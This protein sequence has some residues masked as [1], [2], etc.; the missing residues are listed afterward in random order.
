MRIL[1]SPRLVPGI[2]E[3]LMSLNQAGLVVFGYSTLDAATFESLIRPLLST[4]P[5]QILP[6]FE[7]P[8][9]L[10]SPCTEAHMQLVL[11]AMRS[12][13]L[14]D[15]VPEQMVV[16]SPSSVRALEPATAVGMATALLA[17][18]G[19][20]EV[21]AIKRHCTVLS[22]M[23]VQPHDLA[24]IIGAPDSWKRSMPRV[25]GRW[26]EVKRVH[27]VYELLRTLQSTGHGGKCSLLHAPLSDR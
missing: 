1:A 6:A 24:M 21:D 4:L 11:D 26:E 16:V 12:L 22:T 19:H 23:V 13:S 5:L 27:G 14:P 10:F 9:G 17:L 15:L 3:A 8:P 20:P 7:E 25:R 2:Q 18:P